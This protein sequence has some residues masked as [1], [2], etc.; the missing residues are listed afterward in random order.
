MFQRT[1]LVLT[2]LLLAAILVSQRPPQGVHAQAGFE[3]KVVN[4]EIFL[5]PDGRE[6]SG[7]QNVKYY[8][9][10]DALNEYG[11]SGW[12]LVTAV[13]ENR[14]DNTPRVLHLIFMKK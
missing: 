9:T 1:C 6:V 11:K 13:Y 8:S 14:L 10:Q 2:V 3:Y 7:G 12:Q 4:A 5:T